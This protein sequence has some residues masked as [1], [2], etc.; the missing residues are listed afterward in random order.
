MVV[1][2]LCFPHDS[3][4]LIHLIWTSAVKIS[5]EAAT[6]TYGVVP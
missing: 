3:S 5:Y 1:S 6:K 4:T 2:S